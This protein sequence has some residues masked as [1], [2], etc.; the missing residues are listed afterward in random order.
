MS[1][2]KSKPLSYYR[3]IMR[4]RGWSYRTAALQLGVHF[5]HLHKV[6]TGE[7]ESLSLLQRIEGLAVRNTSESLTKMQNESKQ[8]RK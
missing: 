1:S 3:E 8:P 2:R 6:L 5:G 4:E 7:R